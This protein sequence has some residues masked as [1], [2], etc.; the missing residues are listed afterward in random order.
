MFFP[1]WL[2]GE[3][4]SVGYDVPVPTEYE[5]RTRPDG[6][7]YVVV[8]KFERRRTGSDLSSRS[9]GVVRR[10]RKGGRQVHVTLRTSNG[11]TF[12][13]KTG[14]TFAY[15]GR[16]FKAVGFNQGHYVVKCARSGQ[17]FTFVR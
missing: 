16:R 6:R 14:Q 9:V 8:R 7:Q 10:V 2:T 3:G 17:R 12:G 1:L 5:V 13:V 15:G 4:I 11:Y